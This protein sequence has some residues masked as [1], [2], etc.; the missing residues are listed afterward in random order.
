M[1]T[2]NIVQLVYFYEVLHNLKMVLLLGSLVLIFVGVILYNPGDPS[3]VKKLRRWFKITV[4]PAF[5]VGTILLIFL[6]SKST[7]AAMIGA[8]V[9]VQGIQESNVS[10]SKLLEKSLRVADTELDK[11]LKKK[12]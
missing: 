9:V 7:V 12:D 2:E 8:P 4:I 1:S 6:P 11:A 3:E 10:I 5:I